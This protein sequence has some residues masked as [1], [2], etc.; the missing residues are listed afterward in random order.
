MS[1]ILVDIGH[2]NTVSDGG[3][4]GITGILEKDANLHFGLLLGDALQRID[5]ALD[6]KYTRQ[7][8]SALTL[9]ERV[10]IEHKLA[11]NLF[12]SIHCNSS[13][14][15]N[16]GSGFEIYYNTVRGQSIATYILEE[17]RKDF[18]IHG[19]GIYKENFF[20]LKNTKAVAILLELFFI[21][22]TEDCKILNDPV[23]A[24]LLVQQIAVGI[25][26]AKDIW[27]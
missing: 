12:V 15:P 13:S 8:D 14:Q 17:V 24:T 4:P 18:K 20:V 22:N 6:I 9:K 10:E 25:M 23:R 7:A 3:A 2:L 5:P 21:N 1:L 11:P 26:N 19:P 16:Q 27:Q